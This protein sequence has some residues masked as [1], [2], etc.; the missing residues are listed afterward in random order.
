MRNTPDP[1]ERNRRLR[2]LLDVMKT[3]ERGVVDEFIPDSNNEGLGWRIQIAHPGEPEFQKLADF[4]ETLP[5][6]TMVASPGN[7]ATMMSDDLLSE[8]GSP[9]FALFDETSTTTT[10]RNAAVV[11]AIGQRIHVIPSVGSKG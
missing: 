2:T 7:I 4:I 6:S 8:D 5:N 1:I 9:R 10:I 11:I 3:S